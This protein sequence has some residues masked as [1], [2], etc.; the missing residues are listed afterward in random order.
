MSGLEKCF[1]CSA[2][3]HSLKFFRVQRGWGQRVYRLG[4]DR[5]FAD[6]VLKDGGVRVLKVQ[7]DEDFLLNKFAKVVFECGANRIFGATIAPMT[8]QT[9]PEGEATSQL[10]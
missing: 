4:D 8:P 9:L 2:A 5:S 10:L 1:F 7:G 3:K 6:F